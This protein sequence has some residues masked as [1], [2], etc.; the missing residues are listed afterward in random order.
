[1]LEELQLNL[2]EE[3]LRRLVDFGHEFGNIVEELA[4]H[5]LPH[6]ECVTIGMAISSSL[7]HQ[8]G[9][10]ARPDLERILNCILG[11]GT[12]IGCCIWLYLRP[13]AG[14]HFSMISQISILG[15]W[16]RS[17]LT[18]DDMRIGIKLRT[19]KTDCNYH[20]LPT[21][22]AISY[23]ISR[24]QTADYITANQFPPQL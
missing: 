4:R 2:Y 20:F 21:L 11:P 18:C 17:Y 7:A 23:L 13:S 15:C 6:G 19:L 10:L 1:M 14:Q 22:K 12:R 24:Y 5:E 8:K 9:I 3:D 16:V